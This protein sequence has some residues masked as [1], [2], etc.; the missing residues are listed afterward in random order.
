VQHK[1]AA[2]ATEPVERQSTG[3]AWHCMNMDAYVAAAIGFVTAAAL[4]LINSW[5][6]GREAATA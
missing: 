3:V 4:A 5:L 6:T 2:A 1:G